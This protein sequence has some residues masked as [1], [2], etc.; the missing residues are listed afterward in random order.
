MEESLNRKREV[1][2][3]RQE[4]SAGRRKMHRR[5][6]VRAKNRIRTVSAAR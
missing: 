2:S 6:K 5:R 4:V 3:V 1:L